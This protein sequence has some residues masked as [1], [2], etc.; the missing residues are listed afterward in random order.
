MRDKIIEHIKKGSYIRK[1]PAES[2]EAYLSVNGWTDHVISNNIIF[3]HRTNDYSS[4]WLKEKLHSHDYY[5]LSVIMS[6]DEVEYIADENSLPLH[7]GMIVL[8]KPMRFHMFRLSTPTHYN[9]YVLYFKNVEELFPCAH[10]MDFTKIGD[11]SCAVFELPEQT[12]ASCFKAVE[13]DLSDTSSPYASSKAYLNICKIFLMLSEGKATLPEK[14][15]A[16]APHFIVR[17]KEYIDENYLS[18]SSVKALSKHFFYSR[19]YISR[20]FRKYYNTPIYEYISGRKMQHAALLLKQ[21][22]SV[23]DSARKSGFCNMSSFVKLFKKLYGCT[24]SQ[25]GFNQK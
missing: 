11:S 2:Y 3:S 15:P 19:E 14:L 13:D 18:I 22:V 8:T 10:M 9:R 6:G 20:N 25:Y 24:P 23:E 1:L 7:R 17:I 4:D 5:E 16:P 21:G 12:V